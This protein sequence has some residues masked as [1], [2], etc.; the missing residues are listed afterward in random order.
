MVHVQLRGSLISTL[1]C[2]DLWKSSIIWSPMDL[3][4]G[5]LHVGQNV[6]SWAQPYGNHSD[7]GGPLRGPFLKFNEMRAESLRQAIRAQPLPFVLWRGSM[8]ICYLSLLEMEGK[9]SKLPPP[10]MTKAYKR[11]PTQ[12]YFFSI[13]FPH[14]RKIKKKKIVKLPK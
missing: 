7:M 9:R 1:T 6:K 11:C 2:D 8:L 10:Q 13:L 5:D 14:K 3:S 4:P 12:L